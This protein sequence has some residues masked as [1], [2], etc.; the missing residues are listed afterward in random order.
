MVNKKEKR[1]KPTLEEM[2]AEWNALTKEEQDKLDEKTK[3][4]LT[5]N[6]IKVLNAI[7]EVRRI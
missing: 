2:N 3:L 4:S 1:K 6:E 7:N 5:Q